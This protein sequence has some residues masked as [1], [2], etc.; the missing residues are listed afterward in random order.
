M[1]PKIHQHA[2]EYT[3]LLK[4][5]DERGYVKQTYVLLTNITDPNCK[6]N[7]MLLEEGLRLGYGFLPKHVKFSHDKYKI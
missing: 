1:I 5:R 4:K 3:F 2:Y 7:R 6:Q